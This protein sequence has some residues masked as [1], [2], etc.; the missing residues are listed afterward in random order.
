MFTNF[1]AGFGTVVLA[2]NAL[3]LRFLTTAAYG[4][5]GFAFALESLA[6]YYD[7]TGNRE[8]RKR[9][10]TMA[11][12]WSL[13]ATGTCLALLYWQAPFFV[14][15]MTVH[16]PVI[17][18]AIAYLPYLILLVAIAGFAYIYDGYFIGLAR[19]DILRNTMMIALGAGFLPW[20]MALYFSD[21]PVHILWWGMISFT[22]LRGLT[23]F[24][25][26]RA[27]AD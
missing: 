22:A 17:E 25:A 12:Q 4:I 23:L 3:L 6:G 19:G 14:G 8:L 11:L 1:S 20:I 7:G 21:S 9:S 13:L 16:Q 24:K 2:G 27:L 18:H 15:L 26:S 10:L 5:D